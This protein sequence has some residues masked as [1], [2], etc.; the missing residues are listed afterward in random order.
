MPKYERRK[1]KVS[2]V[3]PSWFTPDQHGKYGKHETFWFARECLKRL[4]NVTP[5]EDYELII[6]DNGS[7]LHLGHMMDDKDDYAGDSSIFLRS[8]CG[9]DPQAYFRRG[10][11]LI[12]NRENLGFGPACNQG[13]A[14]ANGE[15]ICCL[16]NDIL[17]W[18]GWL[19][20]LLNVFKAQT[21]PPVGVVMPALLKETRDA[22]EA[23]EL[24]NPDFTLNAGKLGAGAEFGSLWM[25]PRRLLKQIANR[26]DGYQVFDEGFRLGFGEDRWLWQEI[27]LAGYETYRCHDTRVFHQGNMSI[28]KVKDRREYI[29]PNRERL[30]K[31]KEAHNIRD[32]E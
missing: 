25:A 29:D 32:E 12:R 18:E 27:R 10:D 26:R 11:I 7:T 16:N 28:G 1:P 13:F 15:Y 19:D 9:A 3:I 22:R 17:V 20:T 6:V 23:I 14:L 30:A 31:L 8:D 2:I 21:N 4:I 24:Q 5:E